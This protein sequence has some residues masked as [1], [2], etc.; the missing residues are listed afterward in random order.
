MP[1]VPPFV[2]R[3]GDAP[4]FWR[5]LLRAADKV[6]HMRP[7]LARVYGMGR[8]RVSTPLERPLPWAQLPNYILTQD[9]S[10]LA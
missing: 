7:I 1:Y 2:F 5:L 8:R 3:R 6:Y 9:A 10:S 4:L